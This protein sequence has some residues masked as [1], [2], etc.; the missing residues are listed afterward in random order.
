MSL[1]NH[2]S[3]GGVGFCLAVASEAGA[4][5][6]LKELKLYGNLIGDAGVTA[7]AKACARGRCRSLGCCT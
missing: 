2:K 3:G 4:L 7:L 5:A 1:E 6:N